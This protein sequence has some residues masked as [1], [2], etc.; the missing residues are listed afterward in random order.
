MC[1]KVWWW[2]DLVYALE[3]LVGDFIYVLEGLVVVDGQVCVVEDLCHEGF[4]FW[5]ELGLVP[6][7]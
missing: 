1:C 4:V 2:G 5:E 3:G 7:L 6:G